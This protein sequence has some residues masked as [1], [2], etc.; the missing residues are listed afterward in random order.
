M[1]PR[2]AHGMR[3]VFILLFL[4]A[5]P[6][7]A[8]TV[9]D[10]FTPPP[11]FTRVAVAPDSFG[12]FLRSLPL[13][14]DGTPV[15]TDRGITVRPAQSIAAVAQMDLIGAN[16]QQCAD[17]IIRLRATWARDHGNMAALDFPFTSGD[18]LPYSAYLAGKRPVPK[19]AGVTWKSVAPR[20]G[21]EAAFRAWLAIVMTYAGTISLER[22][23]RPVEG[24]LQGG[25][26]VIEAGS[27][28]HA[29]LV[30]DLAQDGQGRYAAL[31]GQSYMPAQSFHIV[32]NPG[33]DSAWYRLEPGAP[34]ETPDWRFTA[35]RP[36]RFP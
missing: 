32:R 1:I 8:R 35:L 14:P 29:M 2:D 31:L 33:G 6:A 23:S 30:V 16:L 15:V 7:S 5:S 10:S 17:A 13:A 11:G 12:A 26:V 25:D 36:R 3:W 24:G 20:G 21:D 28:G 19:G 18:R 9:G 34:L 4:L 22:L 27:P